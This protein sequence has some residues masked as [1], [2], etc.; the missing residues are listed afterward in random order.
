MAG[1]R[2]RNRNH[3]ASVAPCVMPE[4][5]SIRLARRAEAPLIA[6]LED[7]AGRRYGE[8]GLPP[9]LE[10]LSLSLI[11]QSQSEG[12]LWVATGKEDHPIGFALCLQKP[13][14][15]HLRELDVHPDFMGRG[16]GRAL[17]ERVTVEARARALSAVTLTTFR[18]VPF[19]A[20]LYERLG[21]RVANPTP[22][23]LQ[24]IRDE[25]DSTRLG[26]W[27][28]VAMLREV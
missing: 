25:E 18:D 20:P 7:I 12:L 19:N 22:P 26:N 15:L 10:G 28:R 11:E 14:A 3:Q 17:V 24:Q 16:V 5:P 6:L 13:E 9:D 4:P 2:E 23:F 8:V 1:V 27:P 21:F